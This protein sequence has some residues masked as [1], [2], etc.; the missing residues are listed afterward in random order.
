MIDVV[1]KKCQT[2]ECGEVYVLVSREDRRRDSFVFHTDAT[3]RLQD[4]WDEGEIA[5]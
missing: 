1:V 5:A 4:G 2:E 3:H